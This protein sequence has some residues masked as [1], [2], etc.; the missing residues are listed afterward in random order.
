[1]TQEGIARALGRSLGG[2]FADIQVQLIDL[3]PDLT[4][5]DVAHGARDLARAL[6]IEVSI[7]PGFFASETTKRTTD[8]SLYS[9]ASPS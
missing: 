9:P 3:L 2:V 7:E 4:R 8:F 1:M 5:Q 6:A